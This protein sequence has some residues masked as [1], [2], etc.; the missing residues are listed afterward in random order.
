MFKRRNH[1]TKIRSMVVVF[2]CILITCCCNT[3]FAFGSISVVPD[4][5]TAIYT[6]DDLYAVRNNLSGNYI[7][8]ADIDM[9]KETAKGG[10]YDTGNGWAPIGSSQ[11]E[12]FS[13][14]FDGN[15]HTLSGMQIFDASGYVGLFGYVYGGT[16]KNLGLENVSI[17]AVA[18]KTLINGRCGGIAGHVYQGEIRGCYTTGK[19]S[20]VISSSY[21]GR[22]DIGGI[23]GVAEYSVVKDCYSS[24]LVYGEG[25]SRYYQ[26]NTYDRFTNVSG[27]CG[28]LGSGAECSTCITIGSV[29]S[30]NGYAL[31]NTVSAIRSGTSGEFSNCYYNKAGGSCNYSDA[32][33]LDRKSVV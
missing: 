6:I 5:Y 14:V 11:K 19:I 1:L 22:W 12:S 33:E 20:A 2:C 32:Q 10:N 31:T 9:S 3:V 8:M 30:G 29:S 24:A 17:E 18:A 26:G 16:I 21:D 23:A 4:G 27:I 13:G 7:L 25:S 15:G 28:A